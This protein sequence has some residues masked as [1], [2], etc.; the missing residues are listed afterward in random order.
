M[1]CRN[2]WT[3]GKNKYFIFSSLLAFKTQLRRVPVPQYTVDSFQIFQKYFLLLSKS[4]KLPAFRWKPCKMKR[5]QSSPRTRTS[6]SSWSSAL[7]SSMIWGSSTGAWV[8]TGAFISIRYTG[9]VSDPH[10]SQRG[11]GSNLL[12]CWSGLFRTESRTLKVK[13]YIWSFP[14]LKL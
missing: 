11:S 1:T 10:S 2:S 6:R 13:N 14:F 8:C 7:M 3:M 9:C 4:W 5:L 12:H